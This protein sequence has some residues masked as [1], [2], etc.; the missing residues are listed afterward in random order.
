VVQSCRRISIPFPVVVAAAMAD[1]VQDEVVRIDL[2]GVGE[3]TD[4][5]T[6]NS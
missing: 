2:Y 4:A 6:S 3:F 1:S 5:R